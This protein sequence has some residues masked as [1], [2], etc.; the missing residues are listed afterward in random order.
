MSI[1][2]TKTTKLSA[3]GD[4]LLLPIDRLDRQILHALEIDGR[5]PFRRL[6]AVLDTSEQTVARRYRRLHEAG[7][8]R[9]LVLPA[10]KLSD[11]G[12]LLR[13]QVQPGAARPLA[14]A[15]AERP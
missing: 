5:A 12:T 10:L 3:S 8:V 6:A 9:V 11:Q 15:L 14:N 4:Q 7:V 13:I 2:M 1:N